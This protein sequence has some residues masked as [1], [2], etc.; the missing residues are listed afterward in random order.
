[1]PVSI[2]LWC[3]CDLKSPGPFRSPGLGFQSHYGAIATL[4]PTDDVR[5]KLK[6]VSIPLWCDCDHIALPQQP[7][8]LICFN[9]TM[10][11]LRLLNLEIFGLP[12]VSIPLWC[13][14][15]QGDIKLLRCL[16]SVKGLV[17][18]QLHF[19]TFFPFCQISKVGGCTHDLSV[20]LEDSLLLKEWVK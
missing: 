2:P 14:C 20:N 4:L 13:D 17:L 6:K 16:A 15:D 19:S 12:L 3:D 7:L 9:P 5:E 8:A 1:M 11:R 10:V 18:F